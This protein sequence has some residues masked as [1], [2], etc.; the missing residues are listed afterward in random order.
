MNIITTESIER[1]RRYID[2]PCFRPATSWNNRNA[3]HRPIDFPRHQLENL[4]SIRAFDQINSENGLLLNQALYCVYEQS[5]IF[6]PCMLINDIC[7]KDYDDY[8]DQELVHLGLGLRIPLENAVFTFLT[9]GVDSREWT[10]GSLWK[11]LCGTIEKD[12]A[13]PLQIEE[14][15]RSGENALTFFRMFLLQKAPDFLTEG[16]AMTKS[17]GGSFGQI[18]SAL[19]RV[20]L[21]EYG[22]GDCGSKHSTMY[23]E[24]M[25]SCGLHSYPHCY[26][27]DYSPTSL[28]LANFFH[29]LCGNPK[30]VFKYFG[31]MYYAEA[32]TSSYFTKLCRA[33]DC[34]LPGK[35]DLRYFHEHIE[36]D[37]THRDIVL[38]QIIEPAIEQYGNW[39]LQEIFTGFESF[40]SL[41]TFAAKDL[42]RQIEFARA[43]VDRNPSRLSHYSESSLRETVEG[44]PDSLCPKIAPADTII[45]VK[46]GKLELGFGAGSYTTLTAGEEILVPSGRMYRCGSTDQSHH[47]AELL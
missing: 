27:G 25:E 14:S 36:V 1:L 5:Q 11:Y 12:A 37:L 19:T 34:A 4:S 22:N 15:L 6:L 9:Q 30:N 47:T 26:F 43:V 33:L 13:A 2:S 17:L 29:F 8:Y 40:R 35:I 31:A 39:I 32:S 7:Q 44:K 46:R 10:R 38:N 41:L 18:Q 28:M 23:K 24:A 3:W 16:S 42:S 20:F 45:R 21:D